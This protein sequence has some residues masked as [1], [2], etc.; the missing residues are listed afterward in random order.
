MLLRVRRVA[1]NTSACLLSAPSVT[2]V[3]NHPHPHEV[4]LGQRVILVYNMSIKVND[5]QLVYKS[6]QKVLPMQSKTSPSGGKKGEV[7]TR[8]D[9]FFSTENTC[10]T[11]TT[12]HAAST[13]IK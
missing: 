3:R 4:G 10:S 5:F 11:Y 12:V 6:L 9:L 1:R 2:E 13:S 8:K 7:F